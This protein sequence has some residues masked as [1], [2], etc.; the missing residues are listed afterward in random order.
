MKCVKVESY[1]VKAGTNRPSPSWGGFAGSSNRR[2]M[3][4][5]G[6]VVRVSVLSEGGGG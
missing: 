1:V 2:W 3:L 6:V 5:T 4:M